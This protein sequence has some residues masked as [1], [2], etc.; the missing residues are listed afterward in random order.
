MSAGGHGH[1]EAEVGVAAALAG[2]LSRQVHTVRTSS[3][4]DTS[5]PLRMA[6]RK[7]AAQR[8]T[9]QAWRACVISATTR[10]AAS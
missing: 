5:A 9:T 8:P 2:R 1:S 10:P 7:S 4:A 3:A 6:R